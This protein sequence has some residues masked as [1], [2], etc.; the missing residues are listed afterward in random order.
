NLTV[1]NGVSRRI[2]VDPSLARGLSFYTGAIIEINVKDLP[3]SL[4]GG[5][6]YDGLVG[7]FL[8]QDVPACGFLLG[9]EG[10]ILLMAERNMFAKAIVSSPA[11][12][13]ITV[14]SE[15]TMMESLS[16]A[17]ELRRKKVRTDLYPDADKLGK[18]FKYASGRGIP[19]VVV[20]GE[21]ER[22][23]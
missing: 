18:Q 23:R 11:D 20:L 8:G 4:G 10:N 15:E 2:K 13:L 16:V 9:L 3:G 1:A 22:A 14:W 6:R 19:L 21:D 12:V 7:M 17:T 5:G